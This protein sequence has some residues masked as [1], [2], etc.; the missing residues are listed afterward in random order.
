MPPAPVAEPAEG[1]LDDPA[2]LQN[3]E[4][5]LVW[6]LLDD[7][8]AH[9]VNVAPL[10][11]ALG[12]EGTVQNGQAQAGPGL[13]AVLESGQ[14]VAIL[15]VGRHDRERQDVASRTWPSASTSATRLRPTSF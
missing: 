3:D 7:T 5:L 11:A 13:L 2:S 10:L 4:A 6:V 12:R 9:A 8:M 14:R 15:H 1:S